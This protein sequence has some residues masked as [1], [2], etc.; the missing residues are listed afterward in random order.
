MSLVLQPGNPFTVVRQISNHLDTDVNYVQA[1]IR[2]AYTDAI[3]ET[4]KLT[5]KGSQRFA[6]NWQV[7][8][9]P[10]GQ[11]F[12]ISVVT[13]VYTDSG[14]TTKNPNYGDEEH[15]YLIQDRVLLRGG[16]GL[17]AFTVRRIV[18][19]EVANAAPTF[20]AVYGAIGALQREVNR[21][22]KEATDRTD[23][24]LSAVK[25]SVP[26]PFDPAPI[27]EKID[28]AVRAIE[29]LVN[30]KQVTPETDLGPLH[31]QLGQ[32]FDQLATLL[33]PREEE[34]VAKTA[35]AIKSDMLTA[36]KEVV[37]ETTF[38]M[39]PTTMRMNPPQAP[40]PVPLDLSKLAG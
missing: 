25:E 22:P 3:I 37:S 29:K 13:S 24:V 19:E 35:D 30:D 23:E 1:V 5:D 11:G 34:I 36:L 38:S 40:E 15:T 2:N 31:E 21:I 4:V 26:E 6:K 7:P 28:G 33:A 10:S 27:L 16:G 18:K 14:Y 12:Y 17:D 32:S 20:D 8:A 39:A 9:D